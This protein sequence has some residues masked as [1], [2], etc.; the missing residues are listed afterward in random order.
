LKQ[1]DKNLEGM[2][3]GREG[4]RN[5]G[6]EITGKQGEPNLVAAGCV[7]FVDRIQ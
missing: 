5:E 2:K 7:L 6:R 3:G 4:G 1:T